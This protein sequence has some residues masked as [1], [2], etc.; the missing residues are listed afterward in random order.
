MLVREMAM[1]LTCLYCEPLMFEAVG[2]FLN[3]YSLKQTVAKLHF[4]NSQMTGSF[5]SIAA[6]LYSIRN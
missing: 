4:G 1:M 6:S 2:G 3:S 5:H